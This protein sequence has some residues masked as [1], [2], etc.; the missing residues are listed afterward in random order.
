MEASSLSIL[1]SDAFTVAEID[2]V[3]FSFDAAIRLTRSSKLSN[4]RCNSATVVSR[5]PILCNDSSKRVIV[6]FVIALLTVSRASSLSFSN[7]II[8]LHV[9]INLFL[10]QPPLVVASSAP[11]TRILPDTRVEIKTF[12]SEQRRRLEWFI[13]RTDRRASRIARASATR[14]EMTSE[15]PEKPLEDQDPSAVTRVHPTP[16]QLEISFHAPSEQQT[17][18]E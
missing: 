1:A 2:S 10:L 9:I 15:R 11:I 14:A 8:L 7:H 18:V 3:L 5:T 6:V 17:G 12:E 13:V 16:P 4:F